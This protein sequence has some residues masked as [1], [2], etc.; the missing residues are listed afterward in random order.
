MKQGL[1]FAR[2]DSV[3]LIM[4]MT[5]SGATS[6]MDEIFGDLDAAFRFTELSVENTGGASPF[7]QRQ[8]ADLVLSSL[9]SDGSPGAVG[10]PLAFSR[11]PH[12]VDQFLLLFKA[13]VGVHFTKELPHFTLV[14]C[15]MSGQF[16]CT[17]FIIS[18]GLLSSVF[19]YK[20][21]YSNY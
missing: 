12:C 19:Y 13:L 8:P 21:K 10:D 3:I 2:A 5:S 20:T 4:I 15:H 17:L 14:Y 7:A 9:V 18:E 1:Y 11:I 6:R 16:Y